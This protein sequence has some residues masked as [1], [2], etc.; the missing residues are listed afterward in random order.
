[1]LSK[2]LQTTVISLAALILVVLM[3]CSMAL[4]AI[5]PCYIPSE[6]ARMVDEPLTTWPIPYTSVFDAER[7]LR[8]LYFLGEGLNISIA[9]SREFQVT[10]LNPTGPLGLLMVG[11]PALALGALGISK[12]KDKKTIEGLKN[13]KKKV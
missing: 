7:I 12:P 1:M 6:L 5:T 9:G 3:G 13:G 10:V 2:I 4:D 8:K 11:G